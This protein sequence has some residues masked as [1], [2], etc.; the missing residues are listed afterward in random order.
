MRKNQ[1]KRNL[2]AG[3]EAE[4]GDITGNSKIVA[5]MRKVNREQYL[6]IS[7]NTRS[8]GSPNQ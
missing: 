7:H 5:D 2:N 6:A 1:E 3:D 4:E 8:R